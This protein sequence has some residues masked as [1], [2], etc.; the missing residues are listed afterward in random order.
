V[1]GDN[2]IY[3]VTSIYDSV[4]D[5]LEWAGSKKPISDLTSR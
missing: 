2:S 5:I 3:R 1:T 4:D